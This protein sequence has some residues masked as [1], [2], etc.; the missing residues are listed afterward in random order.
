MTTQ[1]L[2]GKVAI[3]TGGGRGLGRAMVLGLARAG[4]SVVATAARE[5]QELDA[6]AAEA[7]AAPGAGRVVPIIADAGREEDAARMVEEAV[8][9][10]GALHILVNNAGR[11]MKYVSESFMTEPTRFWEVAPATWR[12]VID[13]NVNG[14]FL[15]ARAAVPHMLAAGW[16]RIVNISMN[17]ETMRRPGFSPYGPSKAALES[18]TI[19]WAGDLRDTCVTVNALLPGGPT[20]TGMIPDGFPQAARAELL[21]PAVMVPPLLWLASERSDGVTGKRL[22]AARWREELGD[23][24]PAEAMDHAGWPD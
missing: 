1:Q 11:G 14:P 17:H 20:L 12:M 24:A 10:F 8:A 5:R 13:T 22:V 21:D 18:E 19:I 6:V 3:V 2:A 15:A 9:R 16:G 4:A 23:A 7:Q